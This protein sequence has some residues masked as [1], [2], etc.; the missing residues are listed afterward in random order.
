MLEYDPNLIV[1]DDVDMD[2]ESEEE[3]GWGGSEGS[4][5]GEVNL[6]DNSWKVRK[7]ACLL[8]DTIIITNTGS[9]R[10]IYTEIV[11]L[12]MKRL[13]ERESNV[14][15]YVIKAIATLLKT[16]EPSSILETPGFVRTMT[17]QVCQNEISESSGIGTETDNF[18]SDKIELLIIAV[19]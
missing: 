2:N 16:V 4:D 9:F 12:L 10:K 8:L 18:I 7:A 17:S 5:T 6:D 11:D 13:N 19:A 15:N 1:E 3:E 14:K